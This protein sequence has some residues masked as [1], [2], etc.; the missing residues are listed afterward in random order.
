MRL[1]LVPSETNIDFLRLRKPAL[2]LSSILVLA[3]VLLFFNDWFEPWYRFS[4]WHSN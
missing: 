2:G 4:W 1:K 3:S